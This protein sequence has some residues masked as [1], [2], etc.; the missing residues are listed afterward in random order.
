MWD[1]WMP[2][3]ILV[4]GHS[5][6]SERHIW[7][8][9]TSSDF[10]LVKAVHRK[11]NY[12]LWINS[13]SC[14][15]FLFS[16]ILFPINTISWRISGLLLLTRLGVFLSVLVQ[17]LLSTGLNHTICPV[18]LHFCQDNAMQQSPVHSPQLKGKKV[19]AF[20]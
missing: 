5:K 11:G 4:V 6:S 7:T 13:V 12:L 9:G 17:K 2:L 3:V 14:C 1:K 20:F 19:F 15:Y 8:G 16:W 18:L 10:L